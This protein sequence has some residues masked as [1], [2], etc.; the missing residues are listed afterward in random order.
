MRTIC[1]RKQRNILRNVTNEYFGDMAIHFAQSFINQTCTASFP[2]SLMN[3]ARKALS[4]QGCLGRLRIVQLS[5]VE[6]V[7]Y[8]VNFDR[9]LTNR[10]K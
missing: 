2:G 8:L 9:Y 7:R 1:C 6:N 4:A 3:N 5:L 10:R